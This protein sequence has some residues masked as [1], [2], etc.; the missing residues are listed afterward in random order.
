MVLQYRHHYVINR[1]IQYQYLNAC[2]LFS[3]VGS[4]RYLHW[5]VCLLCI[6][7]V[8]VCAR[9]AISARERKRRKNNNSLSVT[10]D[11]LNFSNFNIC[12][13]FFSF[14]VVFRVADR[15]NIWRS[16]CSHCKYTT[17]IW[18]ILNCS[19]PQAAKG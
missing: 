14:F 1:F 5:C 17:T 13:F 10:T 12:F 18:H 16:L 3:S 19:W 8:F 7:F 4:C 11:T 6:C 15:R 2:S 9:V